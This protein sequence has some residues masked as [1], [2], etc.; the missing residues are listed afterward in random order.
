[1]RSNRA[2]RLPLAAAFVFCAAAHAQNVPAGDPYAARID[3]CMQAA[4]Q[5]EPRTGLS[6]AGSLL[7]ERGLPDGPRLGALT[8]EQ[9]AQYKLGRHAQALETI[10]RIL[11]LLEAPSIHADDRFSATMN[12]AGTLLPL[13]RAD[14][15]LALYDRALALVGDDS[16]HGQ[17]AA[18][19][20]I[21]MV[22]AL[23]R[24]DQAQAE[25]YFRRA[26]AV[27]DR[28]R[29][30]G[31][32]AELML[33][34][35]LGYT[36]L[37]AGRPADAEAAL[38]RALEMAEGRTA[39]DRL[40]YAILSHRGEIARLQGDS[41]T[42]RARLERALAWQHADQDLQGE[43][44]TSI[45]LSGLA[46]QQDGPEQALPHALR[47]LAVAEQGNFVPEIRSSLR[48]LADLHAQMGDAA[49]AADYAQRLRELQRQSAPTG[50]ADRLTALQARA[51]ASAQRSVPSP[52]ST[53]LRDT[54][55]GALA[56]L[57]AIGALALHRA[58]RRRREAAARN[59]GGLPGLREAIARLE[60]L[61]PPDDG[62]RHALLSIE[63]DTGAAA[64]DALPDGLAQRLREACDGHDVVARRRGDAFVV[65]RPDTHR[66]AACALAEHLLGTLRRALAEMPRA[67]AEAAVRIGVAP[68]PFFPHDA[69]QW[70]ASLRMADRA[71]ASV[72]GAAGGWAGLWGLPA[73]AGTD[74]E[75]V[76][77]DPQAAQARGWI[78]IDGERPRSRP[79]DPGAPARVDA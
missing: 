6:L 36:L 2:G 52:R 19:H 54:A 31:S 14:D 13:G 33:H 70:E 71:C 3:R 28:H 50:G 44:V 32:M 68:C 42:A 46:L 45:W 56:L 73:G 57:L 1:M 37:L 21:G 77:L 62:M 79:S 24:D 72:Q 23:A 63:I 40:R 61:P 11:P 15:A 29:M 48:L 9:I 43:A 59:G 4:L 8:C 16:P 5:D 7:A 38:L 30:P 25:A 47:A 74:P 34:Y 64:G 17:V 51:D 22:H 49:R 67:D 35:N 58:R 66:E 26:L 60:A 53:A 18:L 20:G 69:P 55:L 75:R 78:A 76:R 12:A 65:M 27:I 10:E 41:E 39:L